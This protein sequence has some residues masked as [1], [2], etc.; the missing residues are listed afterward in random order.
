MDYTHCP[1]I[2]KAV[3]TSV[4]DG[5]TCTADIDLGFGVILRKQKLRLLG[6]DAPELRG[7]TLEE[8][9]ASRDWLREQVLDKEVIIE[10]FKDRKG[11]YGRWLAEIH[12]G[13]INI[14]N[15]MI[16]EGHAIPYEA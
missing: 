16:T 9:R 12:L 11:K 4:W 15:Q 5:D 1:Y 6:V 7:D 3:I 2:Y 14:N 13:D 8:A 10:T